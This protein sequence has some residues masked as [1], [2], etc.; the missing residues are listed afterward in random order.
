MGSS[1]KIRWVKQPRRCKAE[2]LR[3]SQ[4]VQQQAKSMFV[5]RLGQREILRVGDIK[6]QRSLN[7]TSDNE[8]HTSVIRDWGLDAD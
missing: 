5:V 3:R 6:I 4:E 8:I 2:S 1:E 7:S